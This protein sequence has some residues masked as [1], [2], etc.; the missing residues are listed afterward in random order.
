M[1]IHITI[2]GPFVSAD[3][4]DTLSVEDLPP[5]FQAFETAARNG[6]FVL[7][8]DTTHVKSA[9][10][11]VI[12][13]FS[14]RFKA[15]PSMKDLWLGDAVVLT[16]PSIRFVFSLLLMVTPLPTEV[17]S[18]DRRADAE[19]WCARVLRDAGILLPPPLAHY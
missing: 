9:P 18:F 5:L 13:A 1:A 8:T 6:P 15:L 12:M 10:R 3:V 19:R 4:R 16:S 14:E 2:S 11:A 7:L 17:K